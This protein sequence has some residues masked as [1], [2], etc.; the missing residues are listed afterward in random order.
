MDA[1]RQHAPRRMLEIEHMAEIGRR[2][3]Q[4]PVEIEKDRA[5]HAALAWRM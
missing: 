3:G 1:K 2:I 5:D 4:R